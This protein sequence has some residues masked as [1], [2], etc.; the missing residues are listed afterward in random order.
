[1]KKSG[2]LR[3]PGFFSLQTAVDYRMIRS[4]GWPDGK[5]FEIGASIIIPDGCSIAGS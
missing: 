5:K 2:D 1:M 3:V 4:D